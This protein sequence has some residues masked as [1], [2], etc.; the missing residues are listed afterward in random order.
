[1]RNLK[2]FDV[3]NKRVLVRCDFNVPINEKG[4]VED[5]FKIKQSLPTIEYLVKNNAKVILMSHLGEPG[6]KIVEGLRLGPIQEK[7]TDL[8][9]I[10]VIKA[11]DCVGKSIESETRNM[12]PGEILL[13]ENLRFHKEEQEN[14]LGF[15]KEL[16]RLG[17]IY[18]NDAFGVCHREHASVA[19]ITEFLPSGMGL[20]LEK[21]VEVLSRVLEN[22]ERPLTAIIGGAKI[23]TKIKVIKSFLEKADN[24]LLGGKVANT[25]LI[26]S[27]VCKDRVCPEEDLAKEAKSFDL[28][29]SKI[30]LPKDAIVSLD[31]AGKSYV[32]QS[33]M[34]K[35]E[36]DELLLDIG[37]ETLKD[38]S[39]IV[40][41]AKMIVWAGPMGLFENPL[42]E[43]GTRELAERIV[44]N[45]QAYKII[46]GGD[47]VSAMAKFGLLEK[48][49][50]VSTG[51]GAMLC[52]LGGEKLPGLEALEKPIKNI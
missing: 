18:I 2:D 48:F 35:A 46:G 22:P 43:N 3:K 16:S 8:L 32:R 47:T 23:A 42:F 40:G 33:L 37:P 10:S 29:S 21:E 41:K 36:K 26:I 5:I 12:E 7:L 45:T 24:L 38:F 15:A 25:L 51:G 17:D 39:E 9:E 50:H 19:G 27:G 14:D 30:H 13:L 49:D 1:M 44:E 4:E 52:F 28:G 6:G 20:L 34:E 11:P 31:I